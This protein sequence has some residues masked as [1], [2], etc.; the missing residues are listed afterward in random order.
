M[1]TYAIPPEQG[2]AS[3]ALWHIPSSSLLL[4]SSSRDAVARRLRLVLENGVALEDLMLQVTRP[5]SLLGVQ[6]LGRHIAE[7]MD[8]GDDPAGTAFAPA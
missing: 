2:G 3:Y 5:G 1:E 6:F 4:T 8:A 7:A